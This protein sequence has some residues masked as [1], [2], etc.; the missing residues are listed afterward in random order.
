MESSRPAVAVEDLQPFFGGC[1]I[2]HV[3]ILGGSGRVLLEECDR[4]LNL[5]QFG[6][7]HDRTGLLGRQEL[8]RLPVDVLHLQVEDI[9][10]QA[11]GE[12]PCDVTGYGL[13][14]RLRFR[15]RL[16]CE[17]TRRLD[18]LVFPRG[19]F[20]EVARVGVLIR[21]GEKRV[22]EEPKDV[23]LLS[24]RGHLSSSGVV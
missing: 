21:L 24:W 15:F 3:S 13:P 2:P 18:L 16:P 10:S 14:G 4:P 11:V 19:G 6:L 22:S 12:E 9:K 1:L 7:V 20:E 5:A 17:D 8:F 23:L